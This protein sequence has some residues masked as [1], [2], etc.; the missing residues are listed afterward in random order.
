MTVRIRRFYLDSNS[1][2]N[3]DDG[4]Y[5]LYGFKIT[6]FVMKLTKLLI[7]CLIPATAFSQIE[8]GPFKFLDKSKAVAYTIEAALADGGFAP[9]LAIE[10]PAP[11]LVE[12]LNFIP[13]YAA[14]YFISGSTS[15]IYVEGLVISRARYSPN[16]KIVGII[17]MGPNASLDKDLKF[18]PAISIVL[19]A[20]Y[21]VKDKYI[22]SVMLKSPSMLTI[23]FGL[24]KGYRW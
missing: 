20:D 7:I 10:K 15:S 8:L 12:F 23:G 2:L 14:R 9:G 11:E 17:G 6:R 19:G 16:R 18:K 5:K 13:G 3:S 21:F 24:R 1:R 4:R 22:L